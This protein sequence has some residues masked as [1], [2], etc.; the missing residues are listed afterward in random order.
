MKLKL[1]LFMGV[2]SAL[3]SALSARDKVLSFLPPPNTPPTI[4]LATGQASE[5]KRC[6]G[7]QLISFQH[8][9]LVCC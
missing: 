1:L 7:R 2:F 5:L 8:L 6:Q 9:D 4:V 3:S